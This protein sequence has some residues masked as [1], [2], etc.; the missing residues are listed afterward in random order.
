[1]SGEL[2]DD[3]II[4]A[5]TNLDSADLSESLEQMTDEVVLVQTADESVMVMSPAEA[6]VLADAIA[7]S[8][9][10]AI[11]FEEWRTKWC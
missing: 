5:L 6:A 11:A 1:M 2:S 3:L 4:E 9:G 8:V 10:E 7:G